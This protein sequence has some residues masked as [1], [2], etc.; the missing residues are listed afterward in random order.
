MTKLVQDH[1]L[2]VLPMATRKDKVGDVVDRLRYKRHKFDSITYIYV[3]EDHRLKGVF[4]IKELLRSSV[5]TPITKI[6]TRKLVTISPQRTLERAAIRAIEHNIKAVPVVNRGGE[7]LGAVGTDTIL[8]TLHLEHTEDILRMGGIQITE[9]KQIIGM[10]TERARQLVK[11][12]LPWLVLGLVG[13]F[14]SPFV[15]SRF[16]AALSE[17]VALAFFM[18]L[19]VYMAG[20]IG[21]QTQTIF[22]RASTIQKFSIAKYFGRELLIDIMLS[23]A[24]AIPLGLYVFAFMHNAHLALAVSLALIGA[25]FFAVFIGM[26]IPSL[27]KRFKK[28]PAIGAG[29][30]GTV[31]QDIT[32]LLVYFAVA[33]LLL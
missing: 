13:G 22:I 32:T 10:V 30:F 28:D 4:S 1:L 5:N 12:R 21:A 9:Q 2:T 33:S 31:I 11:M 7:F 27:L 8:K 29:P 26:G 25:V 17:T 16:E 15:I 19:V 14:F 3:V 20:A 18:P 6:M 23:V 24:L